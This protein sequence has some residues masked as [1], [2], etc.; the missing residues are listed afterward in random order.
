MHMTMVSFG[1]LLLQFSDEVDS[2]CELMLTYVHRPWSPEWCSIRNFLS[3]WNLFEA[4]FRL[5]FI[6]SIPLGSIS[7]L[8]NVAA[9]SIVL[10]VRFPKPASAY[11]CVTGRMRYSSDALSHDAAGLDGGPPVRMGVFSMVP[12]SSSSSWF[13]AAEVDFSMSSNISC[14]ISV[15]MLGFLKHRKLYAKAYW[16]F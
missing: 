9:L 4:I 7:G 11:D 13:Q 16:K 3:S 14:I 8:N 1:N 10:H 5:S 15:C 12:R 2:S 6:S